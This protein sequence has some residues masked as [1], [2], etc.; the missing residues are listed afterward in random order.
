[1]NIVADNCNGEDSSSPFYRKHAR[2]ALF[3]YQCS[4]KST[5]KELLAVFDKATQRQQRVDPTKHRCFVLMDEAGL[6][7]E[8][9]ES[10]K[11]LHYLLE[12]HMS[13]KADV[14]FVAISNH[15]LDAAKTNR[16]V[17]LLREEPDEDDMLS[18]SQGV[19][20][21]VKENVYSRADNVDLDGELIPANK[22]ARNLCQSYAT[23]LHDNGELSWFGTFFGLRDLIHFLKALR[24]NSSF[25]AMK[26]RI[27]VRDIVR[28]IERNFNGVA[29]RDIRLIA[30]HFLRPL[31]RSEINWSPSLLEGAFRDPVH[32]ILDALQSSSGSSNLSNKSRYKLLIDGSGD[33]SILRLLNSGGIVSLSK[34]SM[35]KL[36]RMPQ[37]T[38]LEELR[39]VSGVKYAALQGKNAIL[40]QTESINESFY[41]LFNQNFRAVM[42]RDGRVDLYANI[43]V[44]G[45]SRRSLVRPEFGC[46]VHV[47]ESDLYQMPAPFLNRFEKFRLT[48]SDVLY[49]GWESLGELAAIFERSRQSVSK[50]ASVLSE[51][52]DI[53]WVNDRQTLDSLFIDMLPSSSSRT[54]ERA[55]GSIREGDHLASSMIGVVQRIS[56]LRPT[57]EDVRYVIEMAMEYLC[58]EDSFTLRSMLQNGETRMSADDLMDVLQA[59]G[60]DMIPESRIVENLVQMLIT[61]ITTRRLL[62]LAAPESMFAA[63]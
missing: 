35:F 26:M 41:D 60:S 33:D 16:C 51:S 30:E 42:G 25:E 28:A 57:I 44:G 15:V 29:P 31:L 2:L 54:H 8:E 21:N 56:S 53:G 43:A 62:Q 1:M 59:P 27:T 58:A 23:M 38:A 13:A 17:M 14:G 20:F 22:F 63:R 12:G 46:V 47:N 5:S 3:H 11:V 48:I 52:G 36:S 10:L 45:I 4:K 37:D 50:L 24:S 32:V 55:K 9:K 39:L 40:S 6:P 34:R 49:S 61:R 19:L 7:E 18:I